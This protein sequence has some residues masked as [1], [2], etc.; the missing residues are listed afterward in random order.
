MNNYQEYKKI[1]ADQEAVLKPIE[2]KLS[3]Y[4]RG[5]MGLVSEHIRLSP[6]YIQIKAMFKA[7]FQKLQAINKEGTKR[8]KKEI[9]AEVIAKRK[10]GVIIPLEHAYNGTVTLPAE[11]MAILD[12]LT[13]DE[14]YDG[15]KAINDKL[16]PLGYG[17]RYGL[18][19]QVTDVVRIGGTYTPDQ[20]TI[21]DLE[22]MADKLNQ[23][24]NT[25]WRAG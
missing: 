13:G 4:P 23:Q 1:K 15:L 8:F 14:G 20:H 7:E 10:I 18:D 12:S 22:R 19:A 25:E 11:V 21:E 6:E 2:D 9:L 16:K 24:G 3:S 5:E 17:I